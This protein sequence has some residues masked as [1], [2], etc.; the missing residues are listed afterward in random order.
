VSCSRTQR[1]QIVTE[2]RFESEPPASDLAVCHYTIAPPP[3]YSQMLFPIQDEATNA[4]P[5]PGRGHTCYSPA[6]TRPH[7]LFPGQ[8]EA[9]N[10]IP[11]QDEA[12]NAIPGQDEATNAIPRPGRGHKCYSPA[13]TRPQ[14]LF[15]SQDEATNAIPQPGRGHTCYSPARTR[16]QSYSWPGHERQCR[17]WKGL[18]FFI[19]DHSDP[20]R[21]GMYGS[22]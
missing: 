7:M 15:P 6:R 8:D 11:G 16:P 3:K 2:Q 12:T 1:N 4:I 14:M 10:A 21:P 13:R 17:D 9:T 5:R 20:R 18:F 22:A 19:R